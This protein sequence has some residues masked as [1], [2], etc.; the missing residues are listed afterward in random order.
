MSRD[1]TRQALENYYKKTANKKA[2]KKRNKKPEYEFVKSF[3]AWAKTTDLSLHSVESKA[4][5]SAAA[6]RYLHS[7]TSESLPD[8]I[9]NYGALS[10]WIEAKA[11]DRRSSLKPHQ[12]EFLVNKINDGCFACVTDSIEHFKNLFEA[13]LKC[14]GNDRKQLL[15]DA[16]PK[17][18]K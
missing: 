18:R 8:I 14:K 2:V 4:V 10:L 9:G 5:Y 15:M 6:G 3:M 13:Y 17:K 12:R 1:S 16:L 7:Q 11:K